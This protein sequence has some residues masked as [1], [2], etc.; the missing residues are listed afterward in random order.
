MKTARVSKELRS[1]IQIKRVERMIWF[2]SIS[3]WPRIKHPSFY[4][5][6]REGQPPNGSREF[7]DHFPSGY[8]KRKSFFHFRLGTRTLGVLSCT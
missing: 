3:A 1:N 2:I 6:V 5:Y 4:F 8:R 7:L